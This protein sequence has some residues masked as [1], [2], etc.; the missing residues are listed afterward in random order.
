[1]KHH[2]ILARSVTFFQIAIALAAIAV[3][4][5]KSALWLGSLALGATGA[6]FFVV[7]LF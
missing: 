7:G 2:V 5:K 4:T 3:L 1:M 6:A